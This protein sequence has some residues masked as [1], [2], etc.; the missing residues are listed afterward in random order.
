MLINKR[1]IVRVILDGLVLS[2]KRQ[3]RL[4]KKPRIYGAF[5]LLI[6]SL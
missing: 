2:S 1:F 3:K 6:L 5:A 4:Q